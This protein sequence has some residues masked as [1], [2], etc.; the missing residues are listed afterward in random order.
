VD[1]SPETEHPRYNFQT[2]RKSRR[3]KFNGWI[4]HSSFEKGTKYP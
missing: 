1:I 3:E 4:L 2:T